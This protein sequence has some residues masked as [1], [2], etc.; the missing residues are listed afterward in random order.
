MLLTLRLGVPIKV[1]LILKEPL[2]FRSLKD[3]KIYIGINCYWDVESL[4]R[5]K[6]V[7]AIAGV[8]IAPM[9]VVVLATIEVSGIIANIPLYTLTPPP[10]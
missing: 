2:I 1:V 7:G 9:G 5:K 6:R 8:K 3:L 4:R 10:K